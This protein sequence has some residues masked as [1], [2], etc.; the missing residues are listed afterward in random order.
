MNESLLL[1]ENA[2]AT[3][4]VGEAN[5][6][7][8][9]GF[10]N[11]EAAVLLLDGKK[12]YITDGRYA[13]DAR[14][15]VRGYETVV[16]ERG[17]SYV[18]RARKILEEN[19]VKI[20]AV[21]ERAISLKDYD[22]ITEGGMFQTVYC[23]D[24]YYK[25]RARKTPEEAE[26]MRKAQEI[27]D[28]A[29]EWVLGNIKEGM[30]ETELA[31]VLENKMRELGSEGT[32]FKSIVAFGENTSKPHAQYGEVKLRAGSAITLDFGAK[33]GG[34]CSDMTRTLFFGKPADEQVF[35]YNTVA[36]AQ[37]MAIDAAE[38]GMKASDLD[39]VCRDY[40]KSEN[41]DGYFVHSTGHGVGVEIHEKPSVS[42]SSEEIL[43]ENNVFSIEPGLYFAGKF[44]VRIEDVVILTKNGADNLTKSP[45]HLI[46]L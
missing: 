4:I 31:F 26:T 6:Y 17:E 45:K 3:L 16:V 37:K 30:T 42:Q 21:E 46:I 2:D 44:G 35:V 15:A 29:F 7:Y 8:L 10:P 38:I 41:L 32:A 12:Y 1:P 13:E 20:L 39:A 34:Y 18:S 22:E 9:S 43:S 25:M 36:E 28:A 23:S 14:K 5:L 24:F 11:G 27:T 40:F 33:F 19:K